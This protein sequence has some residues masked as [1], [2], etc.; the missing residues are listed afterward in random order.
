ME[1]DSAGPDR[2]ISIT[3]LQIEL[4]SEHKLGKNIWGFAAIGYSFLRDLEIEDLNS[5]ALQTDDI[6][7]GL[8]IETGLTLR[9]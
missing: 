4:K 6:D 2:D 3:S 1:A 9:F 8:F 5:N 7:S